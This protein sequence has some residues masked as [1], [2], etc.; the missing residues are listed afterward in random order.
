MSGNARSS[1]IVKAKIFRLSSALQ[2]RAKA[3]TFKAKAWTFKA[4]ALGPDAKAKGK[5]IKI[6]PEGQG[7]ASRTTSLARRQ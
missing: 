4:M 5:A 7:L 1:N 2:A 6:C 3:W